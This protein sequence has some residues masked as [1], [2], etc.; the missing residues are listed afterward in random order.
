[1]RIYRL[2]GALVA[3]SISTLG[4]V[5]CSSNAEPEQTALPKVS[6]D[7]RA[8]DVSCC[9]LPPVG[10]GSSPSG[11]GACVWPDGNVGC[12]FNGSCCVPGAGC[13]TFAPCPPPPPPTPTSCDAY[14]RYPSGCGGEC[15]PQE[16]CVPAAG[17]GC[18][19]VQ[20]M[21]NPGGNGGVPGGGGGGCA[22]S[23]DPVSCCE[24]N[25]CADP[26]CYDMEI[27]S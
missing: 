22:Y 9:G 2:S 24:V 7:L 1:M 15:G 12:T 21:G 23:S 27:C 8:K 25:G 26:S 17:Y 5:A 19:C 4:A 10:P 3:G 13:G 20:A 18:Q 16:Q 6:V 14:A 11:T